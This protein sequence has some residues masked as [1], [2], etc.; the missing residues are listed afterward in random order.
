[1]QIPD[2]AAAAQWLRRPRNRV[3][4][5]VLALLVAVRVALPWVLRPIIVDQADKAMTGHIALADLDLSL[6]RGGVTLHGLEVFPEERPP[7]GMP[8]PKKPKWVQPNLFDVA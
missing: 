7:E 3:L 6:I 2:R 5:G 4:L 1:M 8:E